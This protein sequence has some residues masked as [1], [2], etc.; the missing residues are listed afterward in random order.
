[1]PVVVD[2][3]A[4]VADPTHQHRGTHVVEPDLHGVNLLFGASIDYLRNI[5]A[6][7]LVCKFTEP[8]SLTSNT[9]KILHSHSQKHNMINISYIIGAIHK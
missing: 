3:G 5:L 8:T 2:G 7:P 4:Q 6:P 9:N 1:M